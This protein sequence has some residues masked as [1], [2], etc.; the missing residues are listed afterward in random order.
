V[1]DSE[2]VEVLPDGALALAAVDDDAA[3]ALLE[4]ARRR[5]R[6]LGLGTLEFR[7]SPGDLVHQRL[8]VRHDFRLRDE[9]LALRRQLHEPEPAPVWPE[10]VGVRPFV[11]AD[12]PAVHA[13]LDEAYGGWDTAYVP[14]AHEE[15][16]RSMMGD[17]EFDPTVWWLAERDGAPVGCS[18]WW[19]SGWLKDV[20][21]R[22]GERGHG[23][24]TALVRHGLAEF[25]RRGL[26]HV[27]LKVDGRNPTGAQRLYERLGFVVERRD[28]VWAL[29]L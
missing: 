3:D 15:W 6:E 27:G 7:P 10:G 14:L 17:P 8:L 16:K 19:S 21:V 22:E 5:A 28:Q 11:A 26:G 23:V 4:E 2:Y 29:S 18:L 1:R 24:G 25:A 9:V 12:A 20:A 13:L